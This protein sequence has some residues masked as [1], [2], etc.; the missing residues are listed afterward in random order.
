M[1]EVD[2]R[3][4]LLVPRKPGETEHDWSMRCREYVM[5]RVHEIVEKAPNKDWAHKII[6]K[7]NQGISVP[8]ISLQMA[9]SAVDRGALREPGQEG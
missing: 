9:Q 7:H 4:N 6:A 2:K 5:K 3:V 8:Y 1:S